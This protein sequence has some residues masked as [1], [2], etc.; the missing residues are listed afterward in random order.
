MSVRMVFVWDSCVR[1]RSYVFVCISNS[2]TFVCI[3][4]SLGCVRVPSYGVRMRFCALLWGSYDVRVCVCM[5]FV[6]S[7]CALVWC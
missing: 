2:M 7:S 4:M 5:G 6:L 1:M 3:R